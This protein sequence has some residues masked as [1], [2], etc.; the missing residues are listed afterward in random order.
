MATPRQA[1][2]AAAAAAKLAEARA[3]AE[4]AQRL[5]PSDPTGRRQRDEAPS[6]DDED[7]Q[8]SAGFLRPAGPPRVWSRRRRS[9][10]TFEERSD[11]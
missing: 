8:V 7:E 10:L 1:A 2:A 4:R 9:A 5:H 3:S 11:V 6:S